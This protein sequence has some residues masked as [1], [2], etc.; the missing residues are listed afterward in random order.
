MPLSQTQPTTLRVALC[1]T[2]NLDRRCPLWVI[3]VISGRGTDV[4]FTPN[5]DRDSDWLWSLSAISDQSAVQQEC[6]LF[7]H[8]VSAGKK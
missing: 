5:S 1:S 7:D 4:S 8:F 2:A 3:S 6:G